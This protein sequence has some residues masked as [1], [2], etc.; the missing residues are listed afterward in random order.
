MYIHSIK[1]INYKSLSSC[2]NE[3]IL[4]PQITSI[5]GKNESGK[6]NVIE[7]I[8]RINFFGDMAPAF[9]SENLNRNVD[10]DA[11]IGYEIVLRPT[12]E[13]KAFGIT[14]DSKVIITKDTQVTTGGLH[15]YYCNHIKADAN[16][17]LELIEK[18]AFQ[19]S[20]QD[21]NSYIIYMDT[22]RASESLHIRRMGALFP[23]FEKWVPRA[24]ADKREEIETTLEVLRTKWLAIAERIPTIFYRNSNKILKASYTLDEVQKELDNPNS[25][26]NSLLY[27]LVH[28]IGIQKSDFIK[29]VQTGNAGSKMTLR[30]R[31]VR[32]I[33]SKINVEFQKFYLAEKMYLSAGMD[34]NVITFTVRTSDGEAL[35]FSERSNGLRWYLNTFIDALYHG[36]SRSNV[37]YLFDEPGISLHVNAQKELLNLF[38]DLADKGNQI[39]YTTHSPYMLDTKED[40]IYRIRAVDK[41]STGNTHVFKTAYDSRLSSDSKEDTLTPIASAIGMNFYDTF[42]P[43]KDKLNIVIEGVSDYIYIHCMAKL[44]G[45]DLSSYSLIP[46]VGAPNCVNICAIL[47][48]WGC[49]FIAVFDYDNAGVNSGGEIL[50]KEFLFDLNV[51]YCYVIPVTQDDIRNKTYVSN[52]CMI[53]DIVT[54]EELVRFEEKFPNA[55]DVGKTLKA[56][57]FSTAVEN[58]E[59]NPGEQC[60]N[61]FKALIDR[62][63]AKCYLV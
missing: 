40:G 46:S 54:R 29:A 25:Y 4:E 8:S 24:G 52:P 35:N 44:L 56:K 37:V 60:K 15:D 36:V 59:Y 55:R 41:D 49:P 47:H 19:L 9:N 30:D 23:I 16:A 20:N 12:V 11:S 62:L 18:N 27:E 53:E 61:N 26:P 32:A 1:A 58:G 6:S 50:S 57:L 3:I 22:L 51:N 33:D 34:A 21:Y 48:G 63:L 2:D 38:R 7:A 28:I 17:L 45:Y 10:S 43:A 31:I 42:G 14:S 13:D 39:V 5:I